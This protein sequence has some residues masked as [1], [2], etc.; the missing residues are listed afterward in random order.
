MLPFL[1]DIRRLK[2]EMFANAN[3]FGTRGFDKT[4]KWLAFLHQKDVISEPKRKLK[5]FLDS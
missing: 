2:L 1:K 4:T 3:F 5:L